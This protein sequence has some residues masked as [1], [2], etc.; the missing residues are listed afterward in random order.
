MP[1]TPTDEEVAR[2]LQRLD[3]FY[4]FLRAMIGGRPPRWQEVRGG[5]DPQVAAR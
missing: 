5:F 4:T 2:L 1:Y 3:D